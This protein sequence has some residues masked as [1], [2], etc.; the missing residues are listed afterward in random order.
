MKPTRGEKR[1]V[2]NRARS[3]LY[4]FAAAILLD[5]RAPPP[6]IRDAVRYRLSKVKARP[7]AIRLHRSRAS[8]RAIYGDAQVPPGHIQE[9]GKA[10]G[11]GPGASC[12]SEQRKYGP[13]HPEATIG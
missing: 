10:R 3:P 6:A 8:L 13:A 5:T 2:R 7:R 1:R 11:T 9:G 4:P 12:L